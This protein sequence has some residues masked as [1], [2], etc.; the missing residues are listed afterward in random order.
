MAWNIYY[1]VVTGQ[2]GATP[3][4]TLIKLSLTGYQPAGEANFLQINKSDD[5][6]IGAYKYKLIIADPDL[7]YGFFATEPSDIKKRFVMPF[8]PLRLLRLQRTARLTNLVTQS[9]TT[10]NASE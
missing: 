7:T 5:L 10:D 1:I 4:E 2:Q 9:F 6:F 3:T 8:H